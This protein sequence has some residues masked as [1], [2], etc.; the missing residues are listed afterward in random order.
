MAESRGVSPTGLHFA[1]FWLAAAVVSGLLLAGA[2][3]AQ[4]DAVKVGPCPSA[5]AI[6]TPRSPSDAVQPLFGKLPGGRHGLYVDSIMWASSA[7]TSEQA[8][9]KCGSKVLNKSAF[10][11][12]G[13]KSDRSCSSC[14][15]GFYMA[16]MSKGWRLWFLD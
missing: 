13:P 9:G 11:S 3:E 6:A 4:A 1:Y 10:I 14:R 7:P 12:I 5:S 15:T 16:K 2:Q 8:K